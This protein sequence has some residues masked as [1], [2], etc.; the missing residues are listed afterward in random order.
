[1]SSTKSSGKSSFRE[2]EDI[3]VLA[4]LLAVTA[5]GIGPIF[6][7][8]LSVSTSSIV[9]YRMLFGLPIMILMAYL[10]GGSLN[11]AVIRKAALPG[12]IFGL[13]FIT[14]FAAVKMTSVAN[15][16]MVGTLQPVLV[17][18][19]APKIFGEKIT[20]KKLAFSVS[21]MLG[22]LVVVM[23]AASTSGAHLNGDLL[24]VL[25]VGIWTTYFVISKQRRNEG[26][27]SWSFLAAVFFCAAIIVLPYGAITSNDLGAMHVSD[28][29]YIVGMAVGPGV[30]GHG[31]MTWAQGHIDVSLASMLG[32]ISP[33]ISSV[34]AWFFFEQSLTPLQLMGGVIV[35]ASLTALVRM[36][37]SASAETLVVHES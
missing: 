26:I 18:F 4:A 23:A 35:L 33:V 3:H 21:A 8:A 6:N 34:L 30:V 9:F 37:G 27:H 13:S 16:T 25:N 28:W 1:V 11:M 17:L 2:R 12:T 31:M 7:K 22:V 20:K 19:V 5:W 32:L 29:W 10:N 14:G 24:A 36:Q 15:A